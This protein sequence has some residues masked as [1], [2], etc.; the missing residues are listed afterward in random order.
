MIK[1]LEIT[2]IDSKVT[3]VE[4]LGGHKSYRLNSYVCLISLSR[5][6]VELK[7]TLG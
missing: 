3:Q 1:E 7:L 2:P 6:P 5:K 4:H